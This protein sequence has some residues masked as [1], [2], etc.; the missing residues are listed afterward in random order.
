MPF[1]LRKETIANLAVQSGRET[2]VECTYG[3]PTPVRQKH[4]RYKLQLSTQS[5]H[6]ACESANHVILCPCT[7]PHI[8][9]R[10]RPV[11]STVCGAREGSDTSRVDTGRRAQFIALF[12]ALGRRAHILRQSRSF[13]LARVT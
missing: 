10:S 1:D 8:L 3:Q 9:R 2:T 13:K 12:V 4:S 11:D 5:Q 6:P 7:V